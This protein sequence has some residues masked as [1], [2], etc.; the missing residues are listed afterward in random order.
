M[1]VMD[2]AR[3]TAQELAGKLK[4]LTGRAAG[5]RR[6]ETEGRVDETGGHLKQGGEHAKD[7]LRS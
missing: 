3:N 7:A 5:D 4:K 1:T 6:L 2:K